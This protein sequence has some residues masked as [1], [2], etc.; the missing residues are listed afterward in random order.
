M[1]ATE[2]QRAL[3][4]A[5]AEF[6]ECRYRITRDGEVHFYGPMPNSVE[7]GWW[8]FAQTVDEAVCLSLSPK[9]DE[10]ELRG[11]LDNLL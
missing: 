9:I 7:R 6:R 2:N 3:I 11:I 5:E 1:I 4:R 10:G 8:L